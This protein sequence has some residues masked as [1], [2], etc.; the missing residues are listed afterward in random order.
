MLETLLDKV[1][2]GTPKTHRNLTLT[3]ILLAKGPLSSLEP[4]S[5]EEALA[6]GTLQVSEISA[7]GSVPELRVKSS[8]DL[9]VLILDGE[10]LVGAKQNRIVNS[11]ILVPPLAEIVIPVSCIEAGRWR[12]SRH[13]FASAGRVLSH[14]A[15][16][17]KADAVTRSLRAVGARIAD[18]RA[19]WNDVDEMLDTLG[20]RSQTRALS[21]GYEQS[22]DAIGEY[23]SGF[24]L[25]AGQVGVVYRIGGALA[26]LDLFGSE[27]SFA[28]AFPK[29]VR[30]SALQALAGFRT[31]D[32]PSMNELQLL[33]KVLAAPSERFPAVGLG[34]ELRIDAYDVGGAALHVGTS[35]VHLFAFARGSRATPMEGPVRYARRA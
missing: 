14:S 6:A 31:E 16:Y 9:P 35:L 25:Q 28:R 12:Y 27:A 2:L 17:R 22:A 7:D 13:N 18:Q 29:L 15:R 21:D 8:G 11:S 30:G 24:E 1:S 10:E 19:V 4:L 34:E 23:L 33:Q 5:L 20:T 3:P 26:G 32:P